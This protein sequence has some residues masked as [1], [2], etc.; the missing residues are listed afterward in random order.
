[1]AELVTLEV[2]NRHQWRKWLAPHHTSSPGVWL[3][4]NKE[5]TGVRS[6]PYEDTVR[7]ALCFGRVNRPTS[8]RRVD[9]HG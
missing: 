2:R 6:I 4:C 9:S 1:M 8:L 3:V 7:E 5:H